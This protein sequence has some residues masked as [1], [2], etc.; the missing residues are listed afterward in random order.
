L[1]LLQPGLDWLE[2]ETG[3]PVLGVLPYLHGLQLE[4]ED[5]V[6]RER[7]HKA[8]ARLHVV[9]PVLPRISNHTDFDAL[10]AHPQVTLQFVGPAETPPACDLIILPGS[11]STRA[12]LAWLR[13]HRW[14]R[15]IE[16]HLRYGGKL[17][18][19]CGGLQML[20][21]AVHDPLGIEGE[22][23]SSVALGLLDLETTLQAHKQLH[24]VEGVLT[25]D[26]AR[27]RGYEIHSGVSHGAAMHAPACKL[28]GGRLDGA[29]SDDDQII[30]S[31]LHGLFDHPEALHALLRWAGLHDAKALDMHALREAS[32]ERL[33]DAVE[34]HLDTATLDTLLGV[35]RCEP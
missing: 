5:A 12:D 28:D 22:A 15:A 25:L 24:N 7:V 33:A 30:G 20:G 1:A 31:Y 17:I 32:I 23:G 18:G 14:D 3:K 21:H 10:R 26:A 19:M 29:R 2:R 34:Q 9:V 16:K 6:P 4:A 8:D 35:T 13:T 11:K 27:V